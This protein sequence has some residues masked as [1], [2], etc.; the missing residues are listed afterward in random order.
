MPRP[1]QLRGAGPNRSSWLA[2]PDYAQPHPGIIGFQLTA[3]QRQLGFFR[4]SRRRSQRR[5]DAILHAQLEPHLERRGIVER[6]SGKRGSGDRGIGEKFLLQ[7]GISN[8]QTGPI[9]QLSLMRQPNPDGTRHRIE[10]HGITAAA[11]RQSCR[12]S[13]PGFVSIPPDWYSVRWYPAPLQ[14]RRLPSMSIRFRS[15]SGQ[16]RRTGQRQHQD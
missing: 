14:Y 15:R 9:D 4:I 11:P 13:A 3:G 10:R 2:I 7:A 1:A 8:R 12:M 5:I 6:I 16:C